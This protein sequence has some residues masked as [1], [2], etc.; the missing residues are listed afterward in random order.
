MKAEHRH[1]LKT[2]DLAKSLMTFPDYVK[3]YG[4]RVILGLAIVVL[5][6]VLIMQRISNSRNQGVKLRDDL[7]Y[8]RS[9]IERLNHVSVFPD[10]RVTVRPGEV[11]SVR[12]LLQEIREKASDKNVLAAAAVAQGDYA[13]GMANYP[14]V[15]A[16]AT[17]PSF[18]PD[19]ERPELLKEAQAAYQE[20]VSHYPEETISVVAARFG[21]AAIAE[22]QSNW[23]EAKTQYD[24]INA[25]GSAQKEFKSLAQI[26]LKALDELRKPILI[27]QVAEKYQAPVLPTF[28]PSTTQAATAPTTQLPTTRPTVNGGVKTPKPTTRP[29]RPTTRPSHP[30]K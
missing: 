6:I 2:N 4:G 24:A 28:P 25:M 7:A 1:E 13:W 22:N 27:G 10:G 12:H 11:D 14:D 15:P 23:D 5:G 18:R 20:V 3:A 21:L 19:K 29:S 17:Q 9:Q 26:K 8:A 30:V 16:A